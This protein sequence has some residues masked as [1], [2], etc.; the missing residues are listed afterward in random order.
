M[1]NGDEADVPDTS[2]A[3]GLSLNRGAVCATDKEDSAGEDD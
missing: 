3:F 1:A 2:P